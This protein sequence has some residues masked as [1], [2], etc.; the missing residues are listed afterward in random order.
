LSGLM[1]EIYPLLA[2]FFLTMILAV[3]KF[4]KRLD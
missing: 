1:P 2:F 3:F 4:H